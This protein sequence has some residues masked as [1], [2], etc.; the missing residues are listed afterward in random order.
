M[1]SNKRKNI[2]KW[3]FGVTAA[4]MLGVFLCL[5][6][7]SFARFAGHSKDHPQ[8]ERIKALKKELETRYKIKIKKTKFRVKFHEGGSL[9]SVYAVGDFTPKGVNIARKTPD[10]VR[11][12]ANAFIEKEKEF[13]GLTNPAIELKERRD[14]A[15][16][17][18]EGEGSTFSFSKFIHGIK[19]RWGGGG[20]TV[21]PKGRIIVFS[22]NFPPDTPEFNKAVAMIKTDMLSEDEMGK[23]A[24]DQLIELFPEA[25]DNVDFMRAYFHEKYVSNES[26]YVIQAMRVGDYSIDVDVFTGEI[27]KVLAQ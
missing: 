13:L 20:I 24:K 26:P 11:K 21:N 17:V 4:T 18:K 2:F 23:R 5:S 14:I 12:I 25:K 16:R 19:Y 7:D 22:N 9:K 3:A 27:V 8:Y 6:C 10:D 15:L 1:E